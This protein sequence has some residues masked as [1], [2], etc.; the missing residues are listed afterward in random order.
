MKTHE[1]IARLEKLIGQLKGF[2]E[3]I[4]QMAKKSPNDALNSFKLKLINST[5]TLA[6]GVL[7]KDF[8]PFE[9][10]TGFDADDVPSNSD[11]TVMIAQ[12]LEEAERC[13]SKQVQRYNG[14][15]FYIL[16]GK[17]TDIKAAPPSWSKK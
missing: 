13:R 3:E 8:I 12:Y 17:L 6:N 15:Y 14:E 5:V 16:N 1:D 7:G 9:G 2:H 4:G 11:V 10:F